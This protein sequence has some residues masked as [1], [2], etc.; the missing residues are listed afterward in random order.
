V[1]E[2][3]LEALGKDGLPSDEVPFFEIYVTHNDDL[4]IKMKMNFTDA[5][6]LSKSTARD[7]VVVEILQPSL[8]MSKTH[9]FKTLSKETLKETAESALQFGV[10]P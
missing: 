1:A 10:P 6:I 8:F 9:P 4:I 5:S 3:K 2:R 7:M